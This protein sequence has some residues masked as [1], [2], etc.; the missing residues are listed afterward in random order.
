MYVAVRRQVLRSAMYGII[1]KKEMQQMDCP[2]KLHKFF[3]WMLCNVSPVGS[4]IATDK[5]APT[6]EVELHYL[7]VHLSGCRSR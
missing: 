1:I 3:L 7:L 5:I 2:K 4:N 6:V